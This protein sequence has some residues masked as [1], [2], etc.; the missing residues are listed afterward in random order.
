MPEDPG[1]ALTHPAAP[2][3]GGPSQVTVSATFRNMESQTWDV[4]DF[5]EWGWHAH[6]GKRLQTAV[7]CVENL[8]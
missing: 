3:S 6:L 8:D 4:G 1:P 5:Q 2:S 7:V